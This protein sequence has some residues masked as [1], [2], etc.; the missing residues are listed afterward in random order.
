MPSLSYSSFSKDGVTMRPPG[1]AKAWALLCLWAPAFLSGSPPELEFGQRENEHHESG[2]R[3][4][5]FVHSSMESVCL[6]LSLFL[7]FF[8]PLSLNMPSWRA[9]TRSGS[10]HY[11]CMVVLSAQT[12]PRQLILIR[13]QGLR[14]SCAIPRCAG[15]RADQR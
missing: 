1:L 6:T 8:L 7:S 2:S 3:Q 14:N 12:F 10:R 15:T 5:G 13:R 4:D 11:Q 9:K